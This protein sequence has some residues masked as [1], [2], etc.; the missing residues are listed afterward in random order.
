MQEITFYLRVRR[1]VLLHDRLVNSGTTLDM[2]PVIMGNTDPPRVCLV[3]GGGIHS[4]YC[5][6][7]GG[8][9]SQA[10]SMMVLYMRSSFLCRE[11]R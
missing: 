11:G 6:L 9:A 4:K 3:R 1:Q 5:P 10:T 7:N 8:R 2:L